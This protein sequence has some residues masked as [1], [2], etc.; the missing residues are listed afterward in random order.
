MV[1]PEN[2]MGVVSAGE[3]AEGRAGKAAEAHGGARPVPERL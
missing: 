1:L 3:D 2:V